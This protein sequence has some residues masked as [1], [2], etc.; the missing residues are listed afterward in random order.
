MT[1]LSYLEF[2]YD[3]SRVLSLLGCFL[4]CRRLENKRSVT[5]QDFSFFFFI[6]FMPVINTIASTVFLMEPDFIDK[7]I[8]TSLDWSKMDHWK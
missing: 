5:L 6:S 2:V 1:L 8:K 4:I 3:I 7:V